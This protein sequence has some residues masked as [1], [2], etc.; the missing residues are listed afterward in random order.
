MRPA[1]LRPFILAL[2]ALAALIAA[3]AQALEAQAA[4]V[5]TG[6]S[7]FD[8]TDYGVSGRLAWNLSSLIGLEGEATFYPRDY[9]E[10]V[11]IT[12]NRL[13][14]LF[15]ATAGPRLG[16]VRPFARL[17]AGVTRFAVAPAPIACV[18]IFPPPL[19]C[20]VAG[21]AT[22]GTL[23]AGGGLELNATR[24]TFVRV[25][26]GDR[27][28]KYPGPSITLDRAASRRRESFFGHDVRVA[29][30]AGIRF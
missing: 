28:L 20:I 21:G 26:A 19:G 3:A 17:R 24:R 11:P 2:L 30:G 1:S 22:M 8:D 7:E 9:P 25:D 12:R 6:S 5:V 10:S 15:G 27:M 29:F 13:E 14:A 16:R 18:A 23:D 4:I